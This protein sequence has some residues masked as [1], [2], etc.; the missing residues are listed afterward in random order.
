MLS[1]P[2]L[3]SREALP[4]FSYEGL[5]TNL[6]AL[7]A[8]Q[9]DPERRH[10]IVVIFN[11]AWVDHLY[12]W[13]YSM[14]RN[15]GLSNFIVG[16]MDDESLVFCRQLR[17]PCFDAVEYAVY[18]D[19]PSLRRAEG[20]AT[21]KVS[22]AMSWIKPRLAAA[23]LGRG[24][25]FWMI[26][27]D[28]TWNAN[29]MKYIQQATAASGGGSQLVHQCDAP[30]RF[31]INSGFYD[32]KATLNTYLLFRDMMTFAPDEN[33]DQTAMRLFGRYDHTF[34]VFN[35]CL[36]K[37]VFDMK[38]NYKVG[39]SVKRGRSSESGKVEETFEWN[40]ME[41]DRGKF[42]WV[43]HHAT[44]LAGAMAKI[45]YLR[46]MNAWFLDDLEKWTL[47]A[48]KHDSRNEEHASSSSWCWI[49]PNE[50]ENNTEKKLVDVKKMGKIQFSSK[51]PKDKI[52][53][54]YLQRRH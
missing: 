22:E 7:L 21:R 42:R 12:N 47:T 5:E 30:A 41:R 25:G 20:A 44:C 52:D 17:L 28:M 15:A 49:A 4:R 48:E 16:T 39:G 19:D 43:I 38:C 36:N 13:V 11:K 34:A 29:P 9:A 37:W 54:K 31:S 10:V 26:D 27:L 33:S 51:Y 18:E 35:E 2:W 1:A 14:V 24:Y 50:N 3:V 23:I 6:D 32:A 45:L 46:T 8:A 40:A 53:E